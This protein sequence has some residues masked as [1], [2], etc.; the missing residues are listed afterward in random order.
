MLVPPGHTQV[1]NEMR[2]NKTK[3]MNDQHI[4]RT[5][6]SWNR[7]KEL[8]KVNDHLVEPPP[9]GGLKYHVTLVNLLCKCA[10][11]KNQTAET[12]CQQELPMIALVRGLTDPSTIPYV[13]SAYLNFLF[14]TYVEVDAKPGVT[15]KM[16]FNKM[17]WEVCG[18]PDTLAM[19]MMAP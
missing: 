4:Y 12:A 17:I 6:E 16:E 3:T 5:L 14:E 8:M 15:R 18:C 10:Q 7:C 13:K 19:Y 11:G 2:Q 9:L 1:I